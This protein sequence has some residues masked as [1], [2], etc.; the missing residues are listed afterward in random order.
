M[1]KNKM[2]GAAVAAALGALL[3]AGSAR[4]EEKSAKPAKATSDMV[5][6]TGIN[7]CKGLGSCASA[8][9]SCAGQNGCKGQGV[10]DATAKECK[11]KG[12]KVMTADNDKDHAK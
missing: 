5:R 2:T 10:T 6:C 7:E 12:G 9:N 4:A 3:A 1:I 11:D 8:K